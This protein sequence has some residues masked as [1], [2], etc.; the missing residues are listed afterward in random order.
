[1]QPNSITLAKEKC[2]DCGACIAVC[3]RNCFSNND[4]AEIQIDTTFCHHCG[5]CVSVCPT[6]ALHDKKYPPHAFQAL[7]EKITDREITPT[8]IANFLKSIRSTRAYKDEKIDRQILTEIID[9]IRYAPTGHFSQ[10][11]ELLLVE[12]EHTIE[13]LKKE[14]ARSIRNFLKKID[15]PLT[16]FFAKLV[17]KGR[18]I[19]QAQEARPRFTRMLTGF[20]ENKDYL[21]HGAPLILIFHGP[22]DGITLKDNCNQAAAYTR[23]VAESYGLGSCFIGYLVHFAKYNPKIKELLQIPKENIIVQVLIMGKPKYPFRRF[24]GRP[25]KEVRWF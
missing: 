23:I 10:N 20:Q 1:M 21:F 25:E 22:K 18:A 17:G 16:R 3:P 4:G 11:V 13:Q 14:S 2:I 7:P 24:V 5:H 8:L 6:N 19:K 15:N 9:V 12:Q